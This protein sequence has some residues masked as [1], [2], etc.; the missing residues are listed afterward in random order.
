MQWGRQRRGR[1]AAG[2]ARSWRD[3][4]IRVKNGEATS[5]LQLTDHP[6]DDENAWFATCFDWF[7]AAVTASQPSS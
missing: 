2:W 6:T 3:G 1:G 5:E 7:A 4:T